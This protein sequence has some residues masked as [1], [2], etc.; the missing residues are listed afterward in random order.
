[1]P[2]PPSPLAEALRFAAA[3][4]ENDGATVFLL[5]WETQT[6]MQVRTY[7]HGSQAVVRGMLEMGA[8]AIQA[9]EVG[10]EEDDDA[11]P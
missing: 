3:E 4:A 11:S 9:I 1:M 6:G 8:E 10:P 5:M 2:K 7:P